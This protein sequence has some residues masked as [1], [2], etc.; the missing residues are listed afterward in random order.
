MIELLGNSYENHTIPQV[1]IM[2][3]NVPAKAEEMAEE[4]KFYFPRLDILIGDISSTIAAH[5]GEGTL[6]IIWQNE[7]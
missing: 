2:H 5:A 4:I 6:A 7:S 3:G 1:Q